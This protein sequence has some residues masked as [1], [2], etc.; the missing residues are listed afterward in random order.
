MRYGNWDVVGEIWQLWNDNEDFYCSRRVL[1]VIVAGRISLKNKDFV[2]FHASFTKN[3]H[4]FVIVIVIVI[5]H[6]P[7]K[8]GYF[9]HD[10]SQVPPRSELLSD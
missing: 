7:P 9:G 2:I 5:H 8:Y 3:K 4:S 10:L 6:F 1:L